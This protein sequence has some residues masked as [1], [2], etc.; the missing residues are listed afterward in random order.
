MPPGFTI[1]TEVCNEYGVN[2]KNFPAG[3]EEQMVDA[4]HTLQTK[5]GK[6]FGD[7]KNPLLVSVRSGA[8][9]SMLA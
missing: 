2:G 7:L 6:K 3:L 1:T 9:I 8:K 5:L 4:L